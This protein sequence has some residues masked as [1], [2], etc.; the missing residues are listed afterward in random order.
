MLNNTSFDEVTKTESFAYC[1]Y[2][3]HP[4][5][6]ISLNLLYRHSKGDI[7]WFHDTIFEHATLQLWFLLLDKQ[8]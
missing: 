2:I 5:L 8:K 7:N 1:L 3:P 6:Q 4:L